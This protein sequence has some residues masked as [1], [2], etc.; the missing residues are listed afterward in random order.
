MYLLC[1]PYDQQ[2]WHTRRTNSHHTPILAQ[3]QSAVVIGVSQPPEG[4]AQQFPWPLCFGTQ[5]QRKL[6][7]AASAAY[8]MGG[9]EFHLETSH[10]GGEEVSLVGGTRLEPPL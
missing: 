4:S 5:I 10:G 2:Q 3:Y 6:P 1:H 8:D 7:A 9:C